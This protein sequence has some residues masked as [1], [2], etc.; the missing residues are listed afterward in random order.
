MC[1]HSEFETE[2]TRKAQVVVVQGQVAMACQHSSNLAPTQLQPTSNRNFPRRSIL[3]PP[4]T[5]NG[6]V[7]H[8][9]TGAHPPRDL[10][11][12]HLCTPPLKHDHPSSELSPFSMT[13]SLI[14]PGF[15]SS[16]S[17]S[18]PSALGPSSYSSMRP[19]GYI[20]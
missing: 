14:Y 8:S 10:G 15:H 13:Q 12:S 6:V 17:A 7:L 5:P 1:W 19:Y 2:N 4:S 11:S 16:S 9:P 3:N 18:S 20:E